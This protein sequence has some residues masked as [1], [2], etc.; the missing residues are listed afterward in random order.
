ME[1]EVIKMEVINP[2]A[3]GIDVVSDNGFT[4]SLTRVIMWCPDSYI[5]VAPLCPSSNPFLKSF[6]SSSNPP[7][8]FARIAIMAIIPNILNFFD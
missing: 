3:A 5:S 2:H 8:K 7:M 4:F 6:Q 1:D